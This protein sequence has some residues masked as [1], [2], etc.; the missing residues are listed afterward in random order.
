MGSASSGF[1]VGGSDRI[2]IGAKYRKHQWGPELTLAER[3]ADALGYRVELTAAA[4]QVAK[5]TGPGVKV[6]VYP[7]RTTARNY[8]LR[9]RDE[10]SKNRQAATALMDA[11]D[12]AAG[13]NCT[14]SRRL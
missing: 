2:E 1:I 10:G 4:H 6:V 11:L 13:I 8:H 5:V 9:V 12:A 3:V 14:F 7:H